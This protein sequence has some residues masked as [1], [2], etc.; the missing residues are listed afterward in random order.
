MIEVKKQ[1]E[2]IVYVPEERYK[3]LIKK[4]IQLN[5]VEK[6]VRKDSYPMK[7][8]KNLL[9]IDEESEV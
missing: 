5:M 3:E 9:D 1:N 7:E 6:Y 8:I 2:I 4:E